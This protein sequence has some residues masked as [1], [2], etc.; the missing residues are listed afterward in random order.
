ML[1]T[2]AKSA[3]V[4]GGGIAGL[5]AAYELQESGFKVTVLEE[6]HLPGGRMAE[7]KVGSFM[8]ITRRRYFLPGWHTSRKKTTTV[9]RTELVF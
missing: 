6:K 8:N 7:E 5:S 1:Q 3:V 2:S 4:V 9:S